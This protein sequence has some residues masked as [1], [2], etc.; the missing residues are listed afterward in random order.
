[1]TRVVAS[2]SKS[3]AGNGERPPEVGYGAN[4]V[5]FA[6][7]SPMRRALIIAT[8]CILISLALAFLSGC[9]DRRVKEV[10]YNHW[11]GQYPEG[12]TD[13]AGA[14]TGDGTG[15]GADE[16]GTG[17][18]GIKFDVGGECGDGIVQPPEQCDL[19]DDN[20]EGH[21]AVCLLDCTWNTQ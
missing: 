19:G 7:L 13:D 16:S 6:T 12:E 2:G 21:D 4:G 1:M 20:A 14:E 8:V 18:G 10:E 17:D 5:R 9:G 3:F 15:D 11:T